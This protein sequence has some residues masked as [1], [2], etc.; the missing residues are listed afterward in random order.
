MPDARCSRHASYLAC[1]VRPLFLRLVCNELAVRLADLGQVREHR[2]GA[3]AVEHTVDVR[4]QQVIVAD[5]QEILG[6]F[7]PGNVH[8]VAVAVE[9]DPAMAV[10]CLFTG[11]CQRRRLVRLIVCPDNSSVSS[12]SNARPFVRAHAVRWSACE[13]RDRKPVDTRWGDHG[14][15]VMPGTET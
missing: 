2:R 14:K 9:D 8:I 4:V 5:G 12:R 7:H 6:R 15:A 13:L 3:G 10:L 11:R 1:R